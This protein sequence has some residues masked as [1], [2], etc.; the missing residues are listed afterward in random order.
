MLVY[1]SSCSSVWY[2][3]DVNKY[4]LLYFFDVKVY[5]FLVFLII[6]VRIFFFEVIGKCS[7]DGC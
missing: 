6:G 2:R 5:L 4:L 3:E 1:G 7:G